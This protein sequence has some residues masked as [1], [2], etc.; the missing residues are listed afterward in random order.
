MVDTHFIRAL[1]IFLD[2]HSQNASITRY[3][4]NQLAELQIHCL[5]VL[6]HVIPLISEHFHEVQG[7]LVLCQ[8]LKAYEDYDRRMAAMKAISA[9]ATQINY[10]KDYAE[11]KTGLIECL[12]EIVRYQSNPLDMRELAFNNIAYLSKDFR[13][14]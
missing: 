6:T 8:F 7:H 11:H 12:V 2:P 10:K 5:A 4:P 1:L 13:P 3:Q 14:H 9:T